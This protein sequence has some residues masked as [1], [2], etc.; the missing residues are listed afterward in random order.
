MGSR[1]DDFR[2]L[3]GFLDFKNV[4][5]DLVIGFEFFAFD[6]FCIWKDAF[7]AAQIH[8]NRPGFA[9]LDGAGDDIACAAGEF[10]I[11]GSSF[12]FAQLLDHDLLS[13]LGSDA[14]KI[15][16]GHITAQ[17]IACFVASVDLLGIFYCDLINC[18]FRF[19]IDGFN[20]GLFFK[21]LI[22]AGFSVQL[23]GCLCVASRFLLVSGEQHHFKRV[24]Y[25][26]GVDFLYF[27][28]TLYCF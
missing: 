3:G 12:C 6:L 21:N 19:R 17:K 27:D 20:N 8:E 11:E 9:P 5:L 24:E 23:D 7:A 10:F 22:I 26:I 28:Q 15:L 4:A 1:K 2:S 16:R 18:I 13:C 14:S 25:D